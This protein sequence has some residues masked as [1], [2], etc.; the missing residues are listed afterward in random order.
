MSVWVVRCADG[1]CCAG[2]L[3]VGLDREIFF[4]P[5][6]A[7]AAMAVV[8]AR[9]KCGPHNTSEYAVASHTADARARDAVKEERRRIRAAI[10]TFNC[11]KLVKDALT[12][13]IF[14]PAPVPTPVAPRW[15]DNVKAVLSAKEVRKA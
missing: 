8:D 2:V 1:K 7:A 10:E 9:M 6:A 11:D 12:S 3:E 15:T 13:L 4:V 14:P 5:R